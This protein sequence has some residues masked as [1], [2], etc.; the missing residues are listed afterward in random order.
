MS[1][2]FPPP[3]LPPSS[4]LVS[5]PPRVAAA[6]RR[7]CRSPN[8]TAAFAEV[9]RGCLDDV[10]GRASRARRRLGRHRRR[11]SWS[12]SA[13]PAS[14]TSQ[15]KAPVD[16][17]TVFR[18]ASMTKSFTAMSIL[19]LRD[20]GKLSLDDPA[21]RYVPEMAG[22]EVSDDRRRRRSRSAI[23]CR[24]PRVSRKTTRGAIGSSPTA[25]SS[26]R[27]CCAAA[28]RSRTRPAS[29]T[30]TPTSASRS[31]AASSS[32]VSQHAVRRRTS[33]RTFCGRSA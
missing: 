29:P 22:A 2:I 7:R 4:S 23:C 8:Q 5:I 27:R 1:R 13:S 33:P 30:S 24:M 9:D 14:A 31:S 6:R 11:R 3:L 28:F 17:D 26:C 10:H 21:E 18:I 15:S 32:N 19:K 12:A 20:E 25:T 16:A